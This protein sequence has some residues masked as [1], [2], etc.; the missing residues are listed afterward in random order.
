MIRI[1]CRNA[2]LATVFGN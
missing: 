1:Y 2:D